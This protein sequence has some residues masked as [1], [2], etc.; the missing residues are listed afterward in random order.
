MT[1]YLFYNLIIIYV[2]AGQCILH[3]KRKIKIYIYMYAVAIKN[4]TFLKPYFIYC[5]KLGRKKKTTTRFAF[6]NKS[7]TLYSKIEREKTVIH[8]LIYYMIILYL[9]QSCDLF[10]KLQNR[11]ILQ[12]Y[13]VLSSLDT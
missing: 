8:S 13:Q 10:K 6:K 1:I 12:F 2:T 9:N 5:M 3:K 11:L 4:K 7:S